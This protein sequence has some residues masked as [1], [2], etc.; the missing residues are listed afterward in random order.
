[1]RTD[2]LPAGKLGPMQLVPGVTAINGWAFLLTMFFVGV[3]APFINF[4]QPYILTEHLGIPINEQGAVSGD[5]AFWSEVVMI[6]LAGVMGAWS[7]TMGRRLVFGLAGVALSYV[8]YPLATSYEE[9]LS[10][11]LIYAVGMAAIGAMT[12]AIMSEYPVNQSRGKLSASV[13]VL[14]TLGVMFV[15]AVLAPL[16]ARFVV[17]EAT[18]IEAGRYTYWLTAGI[19]LAGILIAWFGLSK[20]KTAQN[21][22]ISLMQ[23]LRIGFTAGRNNP[24]IALSYG[25]AF[26]GRTDLVVVVIFLSLWIT[27]VALEQGMSTEEALI[28]AGI[29]FGLMQGAGLLFMPIMGFL[30]DRMNRVVAVAL[31]TG[32]ALVGYLWLGLLDQPM[33][34]QAYPAAIILGM[35]Q[36]SAILT[37]MALVGQ[38]VSETE[39]GAVSGLFTLFGAIGILLATKIGGLL[40]DAWM[41]G[42]P[43]IITGLANGVVL[44][45]ALAM[46]GLGLHRGVHSDA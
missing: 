29:M 36:A 3:L 24:R 7:D 27:H 45:A 4:A 33:G 9:L 21:T 38:E 25:A 11:R 12:I 30:V 42:A 40:F 44:I 32:L 41:P 6:L 26:V 34:V 23:R 20:L 14:S 39:T 1:M 16:P 31:A 8:L 5:L 22:A 37:A 18:A 13:G 28:E 10:Y 35:G 2:N 15:V 43:F 46:V 17:G 19:A